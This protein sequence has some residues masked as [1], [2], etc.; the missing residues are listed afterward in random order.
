MASEDLAVLASLD[1][2][3]ASIDVEETH[4]ESLRRYIAVTRELLERL[5]R[6]DPH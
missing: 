1:A 5:E 3:L 4:R 2:E 6:L